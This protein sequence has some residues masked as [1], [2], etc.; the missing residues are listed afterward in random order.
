MWDVR[1][2]MVDLLSVPRERFESADAVRQGVGM[3]RA[4][5]SWWALVMRNSRACGND[6]I[7]LKHT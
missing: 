6:L 4:V 7:L 2:G 1:K 5:L 3:S